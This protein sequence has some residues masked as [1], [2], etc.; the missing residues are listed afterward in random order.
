MASFARFSFKKPSFLTK[1]DRSIPEFSWHELSEKDVIS[2]GAFGVVFSAEYGKR[3]VVIKK[4][5]GGDTD[6]KK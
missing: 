3:K 5:I 6:D 1:E 4:L 2:Q